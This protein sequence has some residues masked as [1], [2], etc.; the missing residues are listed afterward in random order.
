MPMTKE[1]RP[2]IRTLRGWAMSQAAAIEIVEVLESI[3]DTCSECA[4]PD[5]GEAAAVTGVA[6]LV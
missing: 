3:G 6:D 2:T 5:E 4:A 1:A